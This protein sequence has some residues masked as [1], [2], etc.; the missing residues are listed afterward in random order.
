VTWTLGKQLQIVTVA[1]AVLVASVTLSAQRPAVPRYSLSD[2]G[3]LGGAT[4]EAAGLNTLGDVVGW[5][6]TAEGRIHAFLYRNGQMLD[7]GTLPGGSE[8]FATAISDDGVVVGYGGINRYGLMFREFTQAF[9]WQAGTMRELGALYCPCTFNQRYGTSRALAISR[10]GRVVGDSGV[11][12]GGLTHA[13]LWQSDTMRDLGRDLEDTA[14]SGAFGI[15]D[16][17]QVVGTIGGRAFLFRAGAREDLGVLPGHATAVARAVNDI[18]QVAGDTMTVAGTPHAFLW[19]RGQLQALAALPGDEASAATAINIGGQIVGRSGSADFSRSRAV[20]WQDGMVLD[21]NALYAG[22]GWTLV[23]ATAI[24][25]VGQIA[26]VAL[27]NG[28]PRAFLLSPLGQR[29]LLP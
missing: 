25:N 29:F 28:Q 2:L 5:A 26:G 1:A 3:T 8:S 17:D 16:R 13:F 19:D 9:M 20:L 7:L 6:A 24:N 18:G 22:A 15:N 14:E 12:R 10:G 23:T 21:L 4:S 27:V 11:F